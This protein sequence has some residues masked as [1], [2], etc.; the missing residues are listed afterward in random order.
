MKTTFPRLEKWYL[1]NLSDKVICGQIHNKKGVPNGFTYYT[2][3]IL[4]TQ[5]QYLVCSNGIFLLGDPDKVWAQSDLIDE[6]DAY[7]F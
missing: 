6:M 4:G 2:G 3:R 5:G 1:V 7:E